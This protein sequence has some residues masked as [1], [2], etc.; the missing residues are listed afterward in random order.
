MIGII[1]AINSGDQLT[2]YIP[3]NKIVKSNSLNI[4]EEEVENGQYRIKVKGT[5]VALIKF[6]DIYFYQDGADITSSLDTLER[7]FNN[8]TVLQ[9]FEGNKATT[10]LIISDYNITQER[11]ESDK[12]TVAKITLTLMEL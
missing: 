12:I 3:P 8:R 2:F 9:Y 7:I 11:R 1:K 4:E 5:K 6:N 10:D